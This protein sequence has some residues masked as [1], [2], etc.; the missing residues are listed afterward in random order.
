MT[1]RKIP[2]C[3]RRIRPNFSA[4]DERNSR[5]PLSAGKQFKLKK[6]HQIK[7]ATAQFRWLATDP[8]QVQ[9]LEHN[10]LFVYFSGLFTT[11]TTRICK[12]AIRKRGNKFFLLSSNRGA[13]NY[14]NYFSLPLAFSPFHTSSVKV[15]T[16]F[17]SSVMRIK[18]SSCTRTQRKISKRFTR[19]FE[20]ISSRSRYETDQNGSSRAIGHKIGI[21]QSWQMSK[22]FRCS[23]ILDFFFCFNSRFLPLNEFPSLRP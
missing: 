5:K 21:C 19:I 18:K 9:R 16:I 6:L 11:R 15:H 13:G 10:Q 1:R 3:C 23:K 7:V 17:R 4:H 22:N 12:C 2:R 14:I 8:T 20:L